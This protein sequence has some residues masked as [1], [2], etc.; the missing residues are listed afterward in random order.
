M[1]FRGGSRRRMGA[2]CA[3]RVLEYD[4]YFVHPH[5]FMETS[6]STYRREVCAEAACLLP[7]MSQFR[8]VYF[9]RPPPPP[10][11]RFVPD[12]RPSDV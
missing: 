4:A 2:Y 6:E 12:G 11:S 9:R 5:E 8:H 7:A 3:C 1:L 10:P